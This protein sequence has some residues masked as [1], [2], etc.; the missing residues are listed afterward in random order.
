[1][2]TALIIPARNE[3]AALGRVLAELPPGVVDEVIVVD[4]GST[5]ATASVAAAGGARVV[6]EPVPG[7][8]RACLA[9]LGALSSRIDTVAFMDADHADDP[10]DLPA[11]LAPL[12]RGEADLVIGSR[13]ALAQPGSLTL[14]QR[15]GNRL[16]CAL[17]RWRFGAR[18]T[19]LGPFRAIRRDALARLDMRDQAYGWTVEMQAKAARDGLRVREVPVRYRPRIGRSKISGT[20]KGAVLAGATILWTIARVACERRRAPVARRVLVFL[21]EPV[22]GRVKTRLA[23]AIGEAD[24]AA[25][26]RACVEQTLAHLRALQPHAQLCVDPP[27]A[28]ARVQAWVGRG[29]RLAPQQGAT[30]GERLSRATRQAFAEAAQRVVVIGT[31]SPWIGPAD[32]DDAFRALDEADVVVGPA[33]DGGYYLLGFARPQPALFEGIAWS[34][35]AVFEQ[36]CARAQALGLRVAVLRQGYDVDRVEDLQRLFQDDAQPAHERRGHG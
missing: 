12:A 35:P 30:L 6:R 17:L 36:T 21:K 16:A 1:M 5:D 2:R 24:A 28:M 9:G 18:C 19:D 29:W 33:E 3:A 14:Q 23:A 25:V 7:Y 20:V 11:L 27:E 8:G 34:T 31:D 32:L 13:R 22:P 26:Y 15:I 4:N 10:G